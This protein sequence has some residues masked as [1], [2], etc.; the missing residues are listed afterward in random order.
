MELFLALQLIV[1]VLLVV[2]LSLIDREIRKIHEI[3]FE[4]TLFSYIIGKDKLK[5][6]KNETAKKK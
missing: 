3:I 5:E 6:E 2:W 4:L 1:N